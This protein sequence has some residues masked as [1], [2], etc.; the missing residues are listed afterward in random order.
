MPKMLKK[1]RY[2]LIFLLLILLI[3]ML[4]HR[5]KYPEKTE[6]QLFIDMIKG[7]TFTGEK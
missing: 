5:F 6:T 4:K 7:K 3:F 1:T 2:V